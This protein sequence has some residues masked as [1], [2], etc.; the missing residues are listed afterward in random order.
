M[1]ELE[2]IL[3]TGFFWFEQKTNDLVKLNQSLSKES[4][5]KGFNA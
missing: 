5:K 3:W 1:N 4:P 2:L